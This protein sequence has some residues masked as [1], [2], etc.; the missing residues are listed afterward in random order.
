MGSGI[1]RK[2]KEKDEKSDKES[3]KKKKPSKTSARLKNNNN[4]INAEEGNVGRR[5]E[6]T[7]SDTNTDMDVGGNINGSSALNEQT[8]SKVV[9]VYNKSTKDM[10]KLNYDNNAINGRKEDVQFDNS[11]MDMSENSSPADN[12]CIG[13]DTTCGTESTGR[14]AEFSENESETTTAEKKN[15]N[16]VPL[17]NVSSGDKTEPNNKAGKGQVYDQIDSSTGD[18]TFDNKTGKGQVY[19]QADGSTTKHSGDKTGSN[20]KA[21]N[22]QVY[23]QADGSTT[24][25]SD[26]KTGS[27]NKAG[28]GQVYDQADGSTT[29]HSDDKTGSN[30][31]AR[32]GQVYDQADGSTTKHSDDKTGSDNK[33]GKGQV[34]DQT[35]GST[36]KHSGDKTG[37]NNKTGKG[38]VY[39]QTDGSTTKHSGD[40]TGSDNKTG[41][42]QVHD[43][44]DGSTT[45]Q[46]GDNTCDNK[47]GKGQVY[48]QAD[49]STTKKQSE[50]VTS[51]NEPANDDDADVERPAK[52][53]KNETFEE[54]PPK[55]E[56]GSNV[57]EPVKL[58][59]VPKI[60]NSDATNSDSKQEQLSSSEGNGKTENSRDEAPAK[61]TDG[62]GTSVSTDSNKEEN[63]QATKE[64]RLNDNLEFYRNE[65]YSRPFP[66]A[67]IE[68]MLE[69]KGD[70]LRLERTHSYIQW[71][72][73][74]PESRGMNYSAQPLQEHEAQAIS[75]NES[76]RD[77]V[78]EAFKMMLD[79]YGM[80]LEL[81]P[82]TFKRGDNWKERYEH[83]NRSIHNHFRIT[84]I[85][86]ALGELGWQQLQ[87]PWLEF[88]IHEA[89]INQV[90]PK[91]NNDSTMSH[92]IDGLKEDEEKGMIYHLLADLNVTSH[93]NAADVS[94]NDGKDTSDR[95]DKTDEGSEDNSVDDNKGTESIESISEK[96]AKDGKEEKLDEEKE[97][98]NL[99]VDK[100]D[101]DDNKSEENSDSK[102]SDKNNKGDITNEN[103]DE[104]NIDDDGKKSDSKDTANPNVADENELGE[105]NGTHD[106][107]D[108]RGLKKAGNSLTEI[109][110][111][112]D[113]V[114]D[115]QYD[116]E[117]NKANQCGPENDKKY[118][119]SKSNTNLA[120]TDQKDEVGEV[121]GKCNKDKKDT[122]DAEQ[123]EVDENLTE[124][125]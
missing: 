74:I 5:T 115:R 113:V 64:N 95:S 68:D 109:N 105:G 13:L 98:K 107:A 25:H 76:L 92:F 63:K 9:Q 33:A 10:E 124:R 86:K 101:V 77:K 123:K 82:L 84:R 53:C 61:T 11:S 111:E 1:S 57:L 96:S 117:E 58:E 79:F 80:E 75:E 14:S 65:L 26:D 42:G 87:K 121:T 38:Q 40:K 41:K 73:P 59:T 49:G 37:S 31:K 43:Q 91:L 4:L 29:K 56:N 62:Q 12:T 83:L 21:R 18:N 60:S 67:K 51:Q 3:K 44:T 122:E 71:L 116:K 66:G 23:D 78:L 70:Y 39:D 8:K 55:E 17:D 104:N 54:F 114:S 69:W 7:H 97:N 6:D 120:D 119:D 110:K 35:D 52:E 112:E 22:G 30:N 89:T 27:D 72:F 19:D 94:E 24:K 46:S 47:T 2:K 34:Y 45:K 36:T 15:N 20:N 93:K 28:K 102:G 118:A 99:V 125:V 106:G 88:M 100:A 50:N 90:L 48:D 16:V 81:E 85:I 103:N 32:N 108:L